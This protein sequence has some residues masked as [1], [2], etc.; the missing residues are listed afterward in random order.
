MAS[1]ISQLSLKQQ[2]VGG[3]KDKADTYQN[4]DHV[5]IL[6]GDRAT[7]F[8]LDVPFGVTE[9]Y[10]EVGWNPV[11]FE[12]VWRCEWIKNGQRSHITLDM[13]VPVQERITAAVVAMRMHHGNNSEGEG[14][15]PSKIA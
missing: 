6:P 9:L 15:S 3:V 2:I 8:G 13:E 11:T 10:Q 4:R 5:R 1:P 12:Q 14:S 7:W